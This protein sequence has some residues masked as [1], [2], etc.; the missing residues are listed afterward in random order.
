MESSQFLKELHTAH[1][2]RSVSLTLTLS[3]WGEGM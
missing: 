3:R 1:E 2:P